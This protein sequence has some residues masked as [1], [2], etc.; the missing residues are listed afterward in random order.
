MDEHRATRLSCHHHGDADEV[1]GEA[2]PRHRF[3]FGDGVV[4]IFLHA[5]FLI[6]R[7]DDVVTFFAPM[8]PQAS[9]RQFGHAMFTGAGAGDADFA[10]GDGGQSDK[11]AHFHV[12]GADFVFGA[13]ERAHASDAEQ[14]GAN[15][16]DLATHGVEAVTQILDVRF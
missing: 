11:R 12:I 4:G 2:R 8:H 15:A 7:H 5:Q 6:A 13:V 10:T 16:A 9:Q 1:G 3:D 14:I